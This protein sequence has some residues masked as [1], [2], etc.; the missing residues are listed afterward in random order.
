MVKIN[1]LPKNKDK[2]AR[3]IDF[4]IEVLDVCKDIN[5]QP[6]LDG[7]LAVFLYSQNND[8]VV[9]DIDLSHPE[10]DYPKIESAL[11]KSG[12]NAKIQ[13]WHVLQ[14]RKDNLKVEFGDTDFWYPDVQIEHQ[15]YL[16][17]D[18]HKLKIL[19]LDSLISFYGIGLNNLKL[20][21]DKQQK[22]HE[23]KAKYE[24]LKKVTN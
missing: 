7:S 18:K 2:F 13:E 4:L 16:E 15:D 8:I 10:K 12:F 17:V 21:K 5:I 6:V 11:I 19:K 23:V 24:M 14:V 9:N 20:D 1:K 3:L 22:Y